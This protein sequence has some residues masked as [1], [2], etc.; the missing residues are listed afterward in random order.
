MIEPCHILLEIITGELCR[1]WKL[2]KMLV[3]HC[4]QMYE[5]N[6][7]DERVAKSV[8]LLLASHRERNCV[9]MLFT[10]TISP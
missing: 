3:S 7:D 5:S 4:T 1:R 9:H 6:H 2:A 8:V 10:L